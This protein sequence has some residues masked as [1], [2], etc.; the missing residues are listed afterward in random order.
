MKYLDMELHAV[1][2]MKDIFTVIVQCNIKVDVFL[3][4]P[5]KSVLLTSGIFNMPTTTGIINLFCA[6]ACC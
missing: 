5:H 1:K 6:Y 4:H 2:T 3:A